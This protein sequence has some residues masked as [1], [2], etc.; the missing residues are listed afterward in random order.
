MSAERRHALDV[1]WISVLGSWSEGNEVSL[2]VTSCSGP[3][4]CGT[5]GV[6]PGTHPVSWR[7]SESSAGALDGPVTWAWA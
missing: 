7:A 2:I 6:E 1:G 5:T 4:V 3:H